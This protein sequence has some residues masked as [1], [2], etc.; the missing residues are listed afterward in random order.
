VDDSS[1]QLDIEALTAAV[2]VA[3]GRPEATVEG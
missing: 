2:R 1:P 3:L